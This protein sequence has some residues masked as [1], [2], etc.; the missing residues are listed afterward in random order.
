MLFTECHRYCIKSDEQPATYDNQVACI[1]NC[2]EKT[3]QAFDLYMQLQV[4]YASRKNFRSFVDISK[5]TGMEVEHKHDTQS[6]ITHGNTNNIHVDKNRFS[7]F[8]EDNDK[9]HEDLQKVAF[10]ALGK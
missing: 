4:R 3:Y 6:I 10:G 1:S 7:P 5:F 8:R 2:Q 9:I